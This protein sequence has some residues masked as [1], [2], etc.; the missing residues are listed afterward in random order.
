[1]GREDIPPYLV[2]ENKDTG[3]RWGATF[4][5]RAAFEKKFLGGEDG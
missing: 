1:M 5:N 3:Y 2:N 4:S